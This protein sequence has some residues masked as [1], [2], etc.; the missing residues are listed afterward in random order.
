MWRMNWSATLIVILLLQ[1]NPKPLPFPDLPNPDLPEGKQSW[2]L[3][4][5][6][7]GGLD[8]KGKGDILVDSSGKVTCSKKEMDCVETLS[9]AR[10]QEFADAIAG[11]AA[12]SWE[13]SAMGSCYDCYFILLRLR[14]RDRDER[15]HDLFAYWDSSTQSGMPKDV[16]RLYTLADGLSRQ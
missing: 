16:L 1:A 6:T 7:R 2:V 4:I 10:L 12:A 14:V 13:K 15:I 5:V 8:G 9:T 11:I 3:Q